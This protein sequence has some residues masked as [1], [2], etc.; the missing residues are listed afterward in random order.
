MK[1]L[2]MSRG[3][4]PFAAALELPPAER[5]TNARARSGRA[6]GD[7]PNLPGVAV[8]RA[9]APAAAMQQ[10][11][12]SRRLRTHRNRRDDTSGGVAA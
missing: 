7:G 8:S 5:T 12:W 10:G 11:N 1:A 4:A 3:A 2:A 9:A 6:G